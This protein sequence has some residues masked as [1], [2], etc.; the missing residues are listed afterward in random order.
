MKRYVAVFLCICISVV[1]FMGCGSSQKGTEIKSI[2]DISVNPFSRVKSGNDTYKQYDDARMKLIDGIMK[3]STA[4]E[5]S[6]E[7]LDKRL[8]GELKTFTEMAKEIEIADKSGLAGWLSDEMNLINS[9][10]T[11]ITEMSMP[12]GANKSDEE[13]LAFSKNIKTA[14]N[15]VTEITF[16]HIAY[17]TLN[18]AIIADATGSQ[19]SK[20]NSAFQEWKS[21]Y[22]KSINP[23]LVQLSK[24]K[25]ILQEMMAAL[26]KADE[27]AALADIDEII[28]KLKVTGEQII[29][30]EN[31]ERISDEDMEF[32]TG[33]WGFYYSTALAQFTDAVILNPPVITTDKSMSV[34]ETQSALAGF[35]KMGVSK[36]YLALTG[37]SIP[38]SIYS[39]ED[40]AELLRSAANSSGSMY[41]T[42]TGTASQFAGQIINNASDSAKKL[43]SDFR[44]A[45]R[46]VSGTI[47]VIG[48][49]AQLAS[50]PIDAA[51]DSVFG[52]GQ[53][54]GVM[55][56]TIDDLARQTEREIAEGRL[57][58]SELRDTIAILDESTKMAGNVTGWLA[59][60]ATNNK[61]I[62]AG[63]A[64]VTRLIGSGLTE[65]GKSVVKLSNPTSTPEEIFEGIAGIVLTTLGGDTLI[66]GAGL[67]EKGTH[68]IR[69]VFGDSWKSVLEKYVG[70]WAQDVS[71]AVIRQLD[72]IDPDE[73][74]G[75]LDEEAI[76]KMV[77]LLA[78]STGEENIKDLAAEGMGEAI[79]SLI[80][81]AGLT[82]SDLDEL[83]ADAT[84]D[85]KDEDEGTDDEKDDSKTSN[86]KADNKDIGNDT[87]SGTDKEI[88]DMT[89]AKYTYSQVDIEKLEGL[90][91]VP[92]EGLDAFLSEY[93]G[94]TDGVDYDKMEYREI[95]SSEGD[96]TAGHENSSG[97]LV[98]WRV[99][100]RA[101][102][103]FNADYLNKVAAPYLFTINF[104]EDGKIEYIS[105]RLEN[106]EALIRFRDGYIFSANITPDNNKTSTIINYK[107]G[108]LSII[109]LLE[110]QILVDKKQYYDNGNLADHY[111][112]NSN[113]NV[114]GA[115]TNYH[116]NGNL[117]TSYDYVDGERNGAFKQF[118]E[119]GNIR[120]EGQFVN[121]KEHGIFTNYAEDGGV[122]TTY[123]YVNGELQ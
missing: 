43:V 52:T 50:V 77:D 87:K 114:E 49:G 85:M 17:Q 111:M 53:K 35:S 63:T 36:S 83:V 55:G 64:Y 90:Q 65:L 68:I 2:N 6:V 88:S 11:A 30:F 97:E 7:K 82:D 70:K 113:G 101:G 79:E 116:E 81:I 45:Q 100:Y 60:T 75:E 92:F 112:C 22:D 39:V 94:F 103:P 51:Y 44:T 47:G 57:G 99:W 1:L 89:E 93:F 15:L 19:I 84:E 117:A 41:D 42:I 78:R 107:N 27:I 28:A 66:E 18:D 104:S 4:L 12:E 40:A 13:L 121:G 62:G 96:Y 74:Q 91:A 33:V 95:K 76:N 38:F 108:K 106:Y 54:W 118:Y 98:G 73:F 102:K 120:L 72:G 20:Y 21:N 58:V 9:Q 122:I 48:K 31:D 71:K 69:E 46:A 86:D 123:N 109:S 115:W 5:G 24:S 25:M 3:E 67:A 56:E 119:S 34:S 26:Y 8:A 29:A 37:F 23:L 80:E 32:L 10:R 110:N 14:D 59:E 105:S 61:M 16:L